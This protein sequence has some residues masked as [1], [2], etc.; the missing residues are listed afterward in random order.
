MIVLDWN[1]KTLMSL[2][3]TLSNVCVSLMQGWKNMQS[4][5]LANKGC[6]SVMEFYFTYIRM[7]DGV[8]LISEDRKQS[9]PTPAL[10]L[11]MP[12]Y[13]G[14]LWKSRKYS[15]VHTSAKLCS[16]CVFIPGGISL[17]WLSSWFLPL[18]LVIVE[19][20][21]GNYWTHHQFSLQNF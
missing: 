14:E 1:V 15:L 3:F 21:P 11:S 20:K 13:V 7:S 6:G 18:K 10:R 4:R 9:Y 16:N 8:L 17:T 5:V 19:L 12:A 2:Y